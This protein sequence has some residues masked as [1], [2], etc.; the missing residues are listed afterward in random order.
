MQNGITS[1]A[2]KTRTYGMGLDLFLL[3]GWGT[4]SKAF[5]SFVPHLSHSFK[6]TTIDLPGFGENHDLVPSQYTLDNLC[7]QLAQVI[8]TKGVVMGWSLGGLIVQHFALRYPNKVDGLICIASTPYFMQQTGWPGI[9]PDV[10]TLFTDQ[11]KHSYSRTVERF[12]AIQAMGSKTAKQD[13][14]AL[15]AAMAELPEPSAFALEQGLAL[16]RDA[17][18]RSH[19]GRISCPT[20]RLYG[21]R[22]TLIPASAIDP[23]HALQPQSDNVV[24]ADAAH[25]PFMSHPEHCAHI[26]RQF[27]DN[28]LQE[29]NKNKHRAYG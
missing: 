4:N 1:A 14:K 11:L 12:L 25:A 9:K 16:L 18:L 6:V 2:L 5:H 10:M 19:I 15:R 24:L 26:V 8:E 20:L 29:D 27:I 22:D 3:H 13:I 23:I 7:E 28:N 21:R 17:D